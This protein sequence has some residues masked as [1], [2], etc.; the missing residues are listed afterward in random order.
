[1]VTGD[2]HR[3]FKL[4]FKFK[5]LGLRTK[6]KVTIGIASVR[7]KVPGKHRALP[8]APARGDYVEC[9][10]DL[11]GLHRVTTPMPSGATRTCA[12]LC[13]K[14][15]Q[16]LKLRQKKSPS[17]LSAMPAGAPNKV[18]GRSA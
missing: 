15:Q 14:R 16:S 18:R 8:T 10:G 12:I 5:D 1:M 4:D 3:R 11:A 13:R 9:Q 2:W 7:V 6:F 17:C